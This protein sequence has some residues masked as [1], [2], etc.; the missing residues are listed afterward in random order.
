MPTPLILLDWRVC[1]QLDPLYLA[2]LGAPTSYRLELVQ[3]EL[4][5]ILVAP[6]S[7]L[8]AGTAAFRGNV[9]RQIDRGQACARLTRALLN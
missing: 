6:L 8:A 2:L 5:V 4:E 1:L 3:K 9:L 7:V